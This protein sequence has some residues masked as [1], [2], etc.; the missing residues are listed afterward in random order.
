MTHLRKMLLDEL[1]RRNYAQSTA[2]TYV[3]ALRDFAAYYRLPPDRLG[4]EQVRHYQLHMLRDKGL[5]ART[6]KQHMA[7]IRFF[8]V[9]TLKRSCRPDDFVY[10]KTHRRLPVILS[11]EEVRRLIDAASDLFQRAILMTLYSTGMRRAEL[12]RLKVGN[13]DSQ[14]MVIHIRRGKGDK[15]RD[16][17]LSLTLLETLREYWRWT[18]PQTCL[19]PSRSSRRK[20]LHISARGVFEICRSAARKAGIQKHIG[21]HTLRHSYATHM[22]E[23]GADLCTIQV[24]LGHADIKD[25]TIYLHLSQRHLQACP[26]PLDGLGV[27]DVTGVKRSCRKPKR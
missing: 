2:E 11:L 16:V 4:P 12:T 26:N 22:L 6:V 18:K 24:L 3:R 10:P 20:G 27:S 19:F 14:R 17:S 7:A 8:F 5:S 15:D 23:S 13:I 1:Q 25:T 9:H 21:P